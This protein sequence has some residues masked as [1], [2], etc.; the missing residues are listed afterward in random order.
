MFLAEVTAVHVDEKYMDEKNTFHLNDSDLLAYSHGTYFTLGQALGTFGYSIR[1]K[2]ESNQK[3]P[4]AKTNIEK[5]KK[6]NT[7]RSQ[8]KLKQPTTKTSKRNPKKPAAK[9]KGRTRKNVSTN[10][11]QIRG[12][13]S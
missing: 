1:K 11:R 9:E 8:R 12:T 5:K 7:K 10:H 3:K 4:A 13:K 2:T 6:A